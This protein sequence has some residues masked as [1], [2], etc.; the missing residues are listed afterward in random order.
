MSDGRWTRALAIGRTPNASGNARERTKAGS[1]LEQ[2]FMRCRQILIAQNRCQCYK[3]NVN[4]SPRD[5]TNGSKVETD[6]SQLF[7]T[8]ESGKRWS[9]PIFHCQLSSSNRAQHRITIFSG[10]AKTGSDQDRSKNLFFRVKREKLEKNSICVFMQTKKIFFVW[11]IES[12]SDNLRR[13]KRLENWN[14]IVDDCAELFDVIQRC[15]TESWDTKSCA[16]DS[17]ISPPCFWLN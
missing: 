9:F 2:P 16:K 15:G 4:A 5:M 13:K 17:L 10:P 11:L 6:R 1:K 8:A 3:P 14:V 12:E 7:I